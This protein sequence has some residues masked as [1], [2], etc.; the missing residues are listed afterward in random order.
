MSFGLQILAKVVFTNHTYSPPPL[1]SRLKTLKAK[2]RRR[3]NEPMKTIRPL[4]PPLLLRN[5]NSGKTTEI[6]G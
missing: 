3:R 1:S 5:S 6:P 4:E 2:N